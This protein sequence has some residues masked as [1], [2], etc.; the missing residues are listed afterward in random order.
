MISITASFQKGYSGVLEGRNSNPSP[1]STSGLWV[2]LK[3]DMHRG[4]I[5]VK[6]LAT[7]EN[8]I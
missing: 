8:T 7:P 1:V 3:F 2:L 6:A 4:N 5:S